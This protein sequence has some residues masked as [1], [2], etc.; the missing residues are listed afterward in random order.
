MAESVYTLVDN[1]LWLK[2]KKKKS[3]GNKRKVAC[4]R[5]YVYMCDTHRGADKSSVWPI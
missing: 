2:K 5:M 3:Q 4:I 1:D